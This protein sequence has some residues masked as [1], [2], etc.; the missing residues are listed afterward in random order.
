MTLW[1]F[2]A[3]VAGWNRA[4]GEEAVAPPSV[5]E[6]EAMVQ[7]VAEQEADEQERTG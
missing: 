2:H 7:A 3:C 4:Q 5:S 6:F 1:E